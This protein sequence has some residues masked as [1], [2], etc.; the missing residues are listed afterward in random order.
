MIRPSSESIVPAPRILPC[1]DSA[2]TVEFGD[3]IDPDLNGLVLALDDILRRRA[4]PGLLV[5]VENGRLTR[6]SL[7]EGSLVRTDRG[8]APGSA[9]AE[10]RRAYGSGL[11]VEPHKYYNPPASYL[12]AWTTPDKLGIVYETNEQGL[13]QNIHAGGPSIRY[14]EGC[15]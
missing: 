8:L 10:V 7:V 4:P 11:I 14:V 6:I 2:V 5:M 12:L 1:G 13:V 3:V 9:E 15:S